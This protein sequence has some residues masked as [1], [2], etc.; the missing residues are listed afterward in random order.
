MR[1]M[2][3]EQ[4][5]NIL[6]HV[7][8]YKLLQEKIICHKHSLRFACMKSNTSLLFCSLLSCLSWAAFRPWRQS[9]A[10]AVAYNC[11]QL[12]FLFGLEW[13]PNVW[14]Q[15]TWITDKGN[16]PEPLKC[17]GMLINFGEICWNLWIFE[18]D[19]YGDK[20]DIVAEWSIGRNV[21]VV[22]P[23]PSYPWGSVWRFLP[24]WNILEVIRKT[25]LWTSI[26]SHW[27]SCSL[28]GLARCFLPECVVV[29]LRD[30]LVSENPGFP[31]KGA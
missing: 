25:D 3:V 18:S 16:N 27:Y 15:A 6:C 14:S 28:Y 13:G 21:S 19:Y 8:S 29:L 7:I 30:T 23:G 9:Q 4:T 20:Q 22:S 17:I 1:I 31:E 5:K 26:W 10:C 11:L 12:H 24:D 2:L